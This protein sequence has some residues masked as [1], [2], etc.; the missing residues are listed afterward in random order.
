MPFAFLL[1]IRLG[2]SEIQ[3]AL[4]RTIDRCRSGAQR[5]VRATAEELVSLLDLTD[6]ESAVKICGLYSRVSTVRV[7]RE[8]KMGKE[9]NILFLCR[10]H[11]APEI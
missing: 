7:F 4:D 3:A 6:R 9:L 11:G 5:S 8:D 10:K 2:A 1:P